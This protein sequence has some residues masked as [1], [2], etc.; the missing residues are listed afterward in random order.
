MTQA[1]TVLLWDPADRASVAPRI[2]TKLAVCALL[3]KVGARDRAQ[4]VIVAYNAGL[5]RPP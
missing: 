4:F 5:V 2:P 1:D 3:T